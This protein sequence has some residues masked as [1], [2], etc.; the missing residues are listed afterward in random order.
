MD[1]HAWQEAE[2]PHASETDVY[3]IGSMVWWPP[4]GRPFH[5]GR[6][7]ALLSASGS[8]AGSLSPEAQTLLRGDAAE[9]SMSVSRIKLEQQPL[10]SLLLPLQQQQQ[11]QHALLPQQRRLPAILRAK[12]FIR[13]TNRPGKL[14]S[15]ATAGTPPAHCQLRE[16]VGAHCNCHM[17]ELH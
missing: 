6:L 4:K 9:D 5:D 8:G 11:L 2:A 1:I 16:V 13:L 12:G 10:Q 3:G 17:Q 14:W 15:W 7:L